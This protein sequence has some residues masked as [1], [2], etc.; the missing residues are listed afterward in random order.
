[1]RE[2]GEIG[3]FLVRQPRQQRLFGKFGRLEE[4]DR[5]AIAIDHLVFGPFDR[6]I[7]QIE[8]ADVGEAVGPFARSSSIPATTRLMPD[9]ITVTW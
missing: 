6:G 4:I 1:M 3:Q 5:A 8:V 9:R 2:R 7:E